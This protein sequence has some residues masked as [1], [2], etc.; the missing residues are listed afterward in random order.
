MKKIIIGLII[1]L[2]CVFFLGCP[3]FFD[4]GLNIDE[5]EQCYA[6]VYEKGSSGSGNGEFNV[7]LGLDIDSSYNAYI[8]DSGNNRIVKFDTDGNYIANFGSDRLSYPIGICISGSDV[9]ITDRGYNRVVHYNTSGTFQAVL[10]VSDGEA[11]TGD[12]EFNQPEGID[13]NDGNSYILVADTGNTRMQVYEIS[14]STWDVLDSDF[15]YFSEI[16]DVE[17]DSIT[18]NNNIYLTEKSTHR[19]IKLVYSDWHTYNI[20]QK[21]DNSDFLLG[22]DNGIGVAGSGVGGF[23]YPRGLSTFTYTVDSTE[24]TYIYVADTLNSRIQK[25]NQDGDFVEAWEKDGFAT[26]SSETDNIALPVGM[27]VYE[28]GGVRYIYV[29]ESSEDR[30]KKFKYRCD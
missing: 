12:G 6:L 5:S 28:T 8:V 23:N 30:F 16:S 29:V 14:S 20:A 1:L 11:G 18:P 9:Y 13:V 27:A 2:L 22:K 21:P 10:S 19:V 26:S 15:D 25:F 24:Y 7:P 4:R 3:G 17:F